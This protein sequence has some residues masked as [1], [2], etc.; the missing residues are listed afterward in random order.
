M[1][2]LARELNNIQP[3]RRIKSLQFGLFNPDELRRSSVCE[4]TKPDTFDGSE[5]VINGLFDPRMGVIE[6]GPECATCE[7]NNAMC[8]GHF[9]HIEL[10]LPVFHMH[11]IHIVMK[12]LPCV[13]FRCSALLV[14][15]N[16]K[17]LLKDLKGKTG[18]N[19]F[20]IIYDLSTKTQK[21]SRCCYNEGCRVIQ[22]SKYTLLTSD[23]MRGIEKKIPGLE[24]DTVV[25][26]VA[27]FKEEAIR[28]ITISKKHRITPEQCFEIFRKITDTDCT[29]LGFNPKYSR[30]EWMICTVL[31]VPPPSVRPSVQRDNNQRSEDD[32]TYVLLMIIKANNQ[33]RK[34]IEQGDDQRKI[35]VAY[36][37]LQWNVITLI[38]NKI[39]G[40]PHNAQRSGKLIK[41]L[42]ER[43]TGKHARIRGNLLGKRVDFSARTVVSVEPNISIDEFGMPKKIAMIL[44]YPDVVTDHNMEEMDQIVKNG[45]NVHPGAK[46]IERLE[47]DCFGTPSPC[48][49]NLKHVDPKSVKLKVGD[50][51]HRHIKDGD[52]CLFNRQPSLH[53]MN[54]MGHKAKIVENNTFKLNV[55]VCLAGDTVINTD[56]GSTTIAEFEK[57]WETRAIKS[58]NWDANKNVYDC[59]VERFHKIIPE[60]LGFKSFEI[61]LEN[62]DKI[63]AT[64][65]HPFYTKSSDRVEAKDLKVGDY[66]VGYE[67]DLPPIDYE[68]GIT[69]LSELDV[70]KEIPPKTNVNGVIKYL[71]KTNLLDIKC[72]DK[73]QIILA[74]LIGHIVG[75]GTLWWDDKNVHLTFRSSSLEDITSIKN[76]LISLGFDEEI[77]KI[78]EKRKSKDRKITTIKGE[79]KLFDSNGIYTIDIRR[80]PIAMMFKALGV[81][82]GDRIIQEFQIPYW[83]MNGS[84]MVK[85]QF[86]KGYFGADCSKPTVDTRT[87]YRFQTICFKMSKVEGKSPV[88]FFEEI[89]A[90]LDEFKINTLPIAVESGNVRQNGEHSYSYRGKICSDIIN[91]QKFCQKIGYLYNK[92]RQDAAMYI[93]EYCKYIQRVAPN[94]EG[95]HGYV[96]VTKY[97]EWLQKYAIEGTGLVWK[98]I[99]KINEIEMKEAFDITTKDEN[100]NFISNRVLSKNCKSYNADFDGD[101]MNTF[102][103]ESIQ[104]R[105]EIEELA[106]VSKQIISP[107]TSTP[108]ISVAQDSMVGSYILTKSNFATTGEKLFHY[109]MPI[110]QLKSDFNFIRSR[111]KELWSGNELF[112]TILPNI[113]LK[114][115]KIEIKNGT[116]V[117]GFMDKKTLGGGADGI[118]QAIINQHGTRVCRDFLDNLQRLVIAWMEDISFSIGFGDAMPKQNIK[119]D[120][121]NRLDGGRIE[122][123]ELIRKAQLGL[124]EP[125]LSNELKM[126]KLEIDISNIG[127]AATRDVSEIVSKNLPDDNNFMI[128]VDSGSKGDADNL[129]QIMGLV[130]QRNIEGQRITYGLTGRTLP[131]FTKWDM[132]L[133]SRGFVYNSYMNGTSPSEF[134]FTSMNSRADAINSNIKT[135]ET[136]YIQRRLVKSMEDLKVEYDGTVR[137]ATGNIVQLSYGV[138]GYDSIKLEHVHLNLIK[139]NDEKMEKEY[140]WN[141]DDMSEALLTEEAYDKLLKEKSENNTAMLKE[142]NQLL[143]DRQDLRYKYYPNLTKEIEPVLAP[144][145][146]QRL[147]YQMINQFQIENY[148]QSDLTPIEVIETISELNDYVSHYNIHNNFSPILKILIRSNLSSKQ[149]ILTHK[150]PRSILKHLVDVIKHKLLYAIV[151]PGEM[152]GVVSAQSIGEPLTQ[153]VLKSYHFSGGLSNQSVITNSGVPRIQEVIGFTSSANMKTPAMKIYLKPQYSSNKEIAFEVRNQIEYTEIK[154]LLLSSEILYIPDKTKSKYEEEDEQFQVFQEI[155]ELT[156]T[157]CSQLDTLSNWVLW[158]EFDREIMLRKNIYM[159]D[160]KEEISKN[161]NVDT[162]IHCV[163]GN[164]NSDRLTL[165]IRVRRNLEEGEGYISFFRYL[166]DC[167]LS[168]P[169]RGIPGINR[170]VP[171]LVKNGKIIYEPDGTMKAEN[172]WV[173]TTDG[174]NLIAVL[175]NDYVDETRT[176]SNDIAEIHRLFGIEGTRHTIIREMNQTI[177]EGAS[178][179]LNIR[180]YAVLADLMT[181]RGKVMQIQR[182]G[183]GK[184]PYIGPIG[185]AT[186]EVMDKILVTA[187]IFSEVDD[188]EGTSSNIITGQGV[189]SGTNAFDLFMN[190]DLLPEQKQTGN[191]DMLYPP[192]QNIN[193]K[194][195]INYSPAVV[196]IESPESF[197]FD[198]EFMEKMNASKEVKL[199]NY[200]QAIGAQSVVADDADF[201]FGYGISTMEE[202]ALPTSI[203]GQIDVNITKSDENVRNKRRRKR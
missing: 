34:K 24:K 160:I 40:I 144:V 73:R 147:I 44:T 104:T 71:K 152:V 162:D 142:W 166:G 121:Q 10:T 93:A 201:N 146:L 12:L 185:R 79:V 197:E 103:P 140:Q 191:R 113:S 182:N 149:C 178:K 177:E 123:E 77:V 189:K 84:A 118:I 38:S 59:G 78:N 64:Q 174:S 134:F 41:A 136:G 17:K 22:P 137:D 57:H 171:T 97:D 33:L 86:L 154:D 135:A 141:V 170:I 167:L 36:E 125:F 202:Y 122:S 148:D 188:M 90:I 184:S 159:S 5:P 49:I 199:D 65:E 168:I 1:N 15:K 66:L 88:K 25:A 169:L 4:V 161:C 200:F 42:R 183:F 39:P 156:E 102:V 131:H 164:M 68:T 98:K 16:T 13:C 198:D 29:F 114:N 138:D 133:A 91:T 107:A 37:N 26:I 89:Y 19:R 27:E 63:K 52:I 2:E 53:R 83:I 67:E 165:R 108:I 124:Y 70:K 62:G 110:T 187:G 158:M 145:N 8:P 172:E 194:P 72:G 7:N 126:A 119:D 151:N 155:L 20:K 139:Y 111:E 143:K 61:L 132:G 95:R 35:D 3:T 31:P 117:S 196:P 11:F 100:H 173:L 116:I 28:D 74:G 92:E 14:K 54:M 128:S 81:P 192:E 21:A 112:S 109:M 150:L 87:G 46:K 32:L 127:N 76:D 56:M 129:N 85:R 176:T 75:D 45:P 163:V 48:T 203:I 181:Y 55:F 43:I 30:P 60:E 69:I 180:H 82:R 51:V 47:F 80:R 179:L 6:R 9:G 50:I 186:Y 96:D 175:S 99:S 190:T 193:E 153:L 120:I 94:I 18:E 106:G 23:K 58:S 115:S 101:E 130:G 157:Q 195:E 105:V